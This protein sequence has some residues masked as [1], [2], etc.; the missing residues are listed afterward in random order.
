MN[1]KLKVAI[2]ILTKLFLTGKVVKKKNCD[3]CVVEMPKIR[4]DKNFEY[5][6]DKCTKYYLRAKCYETLEPKIDEALEKV[7]GEIDERLESKAEQVVEK[8]DK[9]T[10]VVEKFEEIK[11]TTEAIKDII[12]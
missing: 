2:N 8:L 1:S 6:C 12:K 4:L 5:L 11:D 10:E 9:A 7:D 3:R